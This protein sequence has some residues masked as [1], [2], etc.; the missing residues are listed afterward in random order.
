MEMIEIKEHIRFGNFNSRELGLYLI[1]RDAPSPEE[2]EAIENLPLRDDIIDYAIMYGEKKFQPREITY[3]FEAFRKDYPSRKVLEQTIKRLTVTQLK[4]PLW[5]SHDIGYHWVG[6]CV[7]V[8]VE[9]DEEFKNLIATLTFQCYPYMKHMKSYFDDVWNTFNF[10][11]DYSTWTKFKVDGEKTIKLY[12]TGD[13]RIDVDILVDSSKPITETTGGTTTTQVT[14]VVTVPAKT[15][16]VK[17]GDMLWS[18]AQKYGVTVNDIKKWNNLSRDWAYPGDVLIVK[19]A[20]TTTKLVDVTTG[21]E[22]ITKSYFMSI[23]DSQGNVVYLDNGAN[24]NHDLV[25]H[26]GENKLTIKGRG[27]ISFRSQAEVMG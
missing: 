7:S 17:S 23:T 13:H 16:V 14:E 1:S 24:Y 19:P 8:Q 26:V 4:G 2:K 11:A 22:T 25:L 9:D 18:L 6:K 10:E 3:V 15:H 20:S 5:D 27:M 21:D 12:N